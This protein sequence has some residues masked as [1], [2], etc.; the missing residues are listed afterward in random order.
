M[1]AILSMGRWVHLMAFP[2]QYT[3]QTHSTLVQ[4]PRQY[5]KICLISFRNWN[6]LQTCLTIIPISVTTSF[7][8]F[9]QKMA[10]WRQ[11]ESHTMNKVSE[12]SLNYERSCGQRRFLQDFDLT[13]YSH[14]WISHQNDISVLVKESIP[15]W[16][17]YEP[18]CFTIGRM[19]P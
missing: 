13:H 5:S 8:N 16:N 14:W 17:V 10:V 1:A 4:G 18:D 15:M 7:W 2:F 11:Y 9:T 19:S 3:Q 12:G 6:L